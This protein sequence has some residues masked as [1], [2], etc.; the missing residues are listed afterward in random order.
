MTDSA[1]KQKP[2]ACSSR[3]LPTKY[4]NLKRVKKNKLDEFQK[5]C[6]A[7]KAAANALQILEERGMGSTLWAQKETRKLSALEKLLDACLK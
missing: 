4:S 2:E 3:K 5:L 6:N 7:W 1:S